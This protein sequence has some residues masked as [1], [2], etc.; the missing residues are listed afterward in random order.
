MAIRDKLIPI[1]V[2]SPLFLQNLDT[3]VMSTALPTIA[4]ALQVQP[5]HLNLAITSYLLSLAVFLPLSGWCADRFGAKRVFCWA[6]VLFSTGSAL[7][8]AADSMTWL[9][10]SRVLQGLG[11]AL[12]VPV[13]RLI[14]LRAIPASQL[15]AATVWFTV[16]PAVGRMAGPLFG[17]VI[18]TW[19]SWRWIFLINIPFGLLSIALALWFIEPDKAPQR[20][21]PFDLRGFVLLSIG[22]IAMIGGLETF[23]R[24]L[25]PPWLTWSGVA[26]GLLSFIAYYQYSKVKDHPIIDLRVMNWRVYYACIIGG[27]PL[28]I[29]IGATPFLLPLLFQIGFGLSPLES[30]V[31]TVGTAVG[32]LSARPLM[33]RL[34]RRSGFRWMLIGATAMTGLFYMSYSLFRADT[35]Q[36]LIFAT[37]ALGGVCNALGMIALQSLNFSDLPKPLMSHG[38]AFA[39]MTQQATLSLGVVIGA[40]LVN[41]AAWWRGGEP[42]HLIAADFAPAFIIVGL[43][44]LLSIF[45]FW[46][47][48]RDVGASMQ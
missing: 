27:T 42:S 28:R 5:L 22:L 47:L 46:S 26:L 44:T 30:G 8:G 21:Q 2:A 11:G 10:A 23:G 15:V 9:V 3:S 38:T 18:V 16:P 7:C 17:G 35:P 32:S 29:A 41:L 40:S 36:V 1:I 25:M 14:L 34:L 13:G 6:I 39:T 48:R 33:Q 45:Q 19:T 12:M 31:L 4:L 37:L 24:A 20:P 43:I